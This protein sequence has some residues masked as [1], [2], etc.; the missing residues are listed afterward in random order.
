[1]FPPIIFETPHH[2]IVD[3]ASSCESPDFFKHV[4]TSLCTEPSDP[5]HSTLMFALIPFVSSSLISS[6]YFSAFLNTIRGGLARK[7]RALAISLRKGP[8]TQSRFAGISEQCS[9]LHYLVNT[10]AKWSEA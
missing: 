10:K 4:L 8:Q 2:F 1:M 5:K 3:F 7:I 6:L 9:W